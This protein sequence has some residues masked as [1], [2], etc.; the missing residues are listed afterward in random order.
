MSVLQH[1]KVWGT[2]TCLHASQTFSRHMLWL[3]PLT[4]CSVHYHA[5]RSNWFCVIEGRVQIARFM[6]WQEE[7]VELTAGGVAEIPSRVPHQFRVVEQSIMLEEY[8]PDP[9]GGAVDQDDIVRLC[10]GGT[11]KAAEDFKG[12]YEELRTLHKEW[13]K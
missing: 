1:E 2:T 3:R 10:E 7:A 6:G 5:H 13:H 11:V 4:Y 8:L 12:L 9:V